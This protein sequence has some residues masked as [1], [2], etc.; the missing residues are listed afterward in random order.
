MSKYSE[1]CNSFQKCHEATMRLKNFYAKIAAEIIN[2]FIELNDISEDNIIMLKNPDDTNKDSGKT[3]SSYGAIKILEKAQGSFD[4]LY[5]IRLNPSKDILFETWIFHFK[6]LIIKKTKVK[7]TLKKKTFKINPNN[8]SDFKQI[9]EYIYTK[10]KKLYESWEE[11][12]ES[13]IKRTKSTEDIPKENIKEEKS[14]IKRNYRK[15][16]GLWDID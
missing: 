8:K 4:M 2:S 14:Q 12:A 15:F 16:R 5:K 10:V 13:T 7:I 11:T 9:G 1:L 6:I 3:T